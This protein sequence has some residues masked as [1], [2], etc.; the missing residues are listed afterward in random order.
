[1]TDLNKLIN[2]ID[3][4]KTREKEINELITDKAYDV[5]LKEINIEFE[6]IVKDIDIVKKIVLNEENLNSYIDAINEINRRSGFCL[7]GRVS[8][9]IT[10]PIITIEFNDGQ[11]LTLGANKVVTPN[12]IFNLYFYTNGV[13]N[14]NLKENKLTKLMRP[15]SCNGGAFVFDSL[16]PESKYSIDVLSRIYKYI[17]MNKFVK[18]F[19]M[20]KYVGFNIQNNIFKNYENQ[21][22]DYG[23]KNKL[24]NVE[25][26]EIIRQ[27][28]SVNVYKLKE[29]TKVHKE[30]IIDE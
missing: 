6:N 21:I 19:H 18:L 3:D 2:E 27:L 20:L 14:V 26:Y 12:E 29:T 28:C 5:T 23:R 1:M 17:D 9:K 13:N 30:I 25:L 10:G 7:H 16:Y 22:Y 8:I 11:Y 24:I 15:P 4:L